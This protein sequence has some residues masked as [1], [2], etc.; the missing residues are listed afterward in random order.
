MDGFDQGETCCECDDGCEVPLCLLAAQ[1]DPLETLELSDR[2]LDAGAAFV[3]GLCEEARL[4][5]LVGLAR[6]NRDDAAWLALLA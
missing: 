6:D 5:L 3:D 1:G 2:L 4:V